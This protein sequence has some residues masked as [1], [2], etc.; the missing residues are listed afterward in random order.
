MQGTGPAVTSSEA[1]DY[2]DNDSP[3]GRY[4]K[5]DL[6][7]L[8]DELGIA[9]GPTRDGEAAEAAGGA[10]AQPEGAGATSTTG[11][12]EE[13]DNFDDSMP[14][15]SSGPVVKSSASASSAAAAGEGGG[16]GAGA[17]R[18]EGRRTNRASFD[19]YDF[20]TLH[21]VGSL[22]MG[23]S[24][25]QGGAPQLAATRSMDAQGNKRP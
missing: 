2:L 25:N 17:A 18:R 12:E 15:I 16:A 11:E 5:A 24:S 9:A 10:A 3:S 8:G 4:S 21:K 13:D 19:G 20:N 22:R 7:K 6:D 1:Q 23:V 14:D